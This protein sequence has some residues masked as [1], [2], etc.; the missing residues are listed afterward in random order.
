MRVADAIFQRLKSETDCVF[1]VPGGSSMFLVDALGRSGIQHVSAIHEQGAGAMALGYAMTSG[2]KKIM[3][4]VIDIKTKGGLSVD[5]GARETYVNNYRLGVCCTISG[6]G[7][8]NAI[9]P[10]LAAWNDSVPVLFISGQARTETFGGGVGLRTHGLQPADIVRIVKPITK[11][12]YEPQGNHDAIMALEDMI[13]TCLSGRR[14]P[15]WL[16]IPQDVQAMEL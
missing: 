6:P 3:S 12:A 9:T 16:S 8:T 11:I 2:S 5:V 4:N 15:C 1:F 13:E 10:C 14:G 7:A